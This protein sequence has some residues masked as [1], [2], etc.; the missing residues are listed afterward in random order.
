MKS[1]QAIIMGTLTTALLISTACKKKT[2]TEEVAGPV[3]IHPDLVCPEGTHGEGFPPPDGNFV[4][5]VLDGMIG[6][7][8]KQGPSIEWYPNGQKRSTGDYAA[9]KRAGDWIHWYE[10]GV[11]EKQGPYINNVADGHWIEFHPSGMQSAEGDRANGRE[12]GLWVY[13]SDG[14]NIRTEG[15]WVS[16]QKDGEWTDFSP[17]GKPLRQRVYRLGR[18]INQREF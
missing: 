10:S 8:I 7:T 2:V 1:H 17:E 18:L 3:Q 15:H 6:T 9:D 4:Y 12:K 5:C 13:W 14:D 11:I 16:G